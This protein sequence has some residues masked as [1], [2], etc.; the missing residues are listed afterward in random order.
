LARGDEQ[1]SDNLTV[2]IDE[3]YNGFVHGGEGGEPLFD[4]EGQ[5]TPMLERTVRFLQRYLAE[6]ERT[7]AFVKRMVELELLVRRDVQ[8]TDAEGNQY[9]L[10][11]FRVIDADQL[12]KLADETVVEL[13]RQGYLGWIHAQLVSM[14]RLERMPLTLARAA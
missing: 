1:D 7:R 8:L 3:S 4:S 6:S 5:Q 9:A 14:S 13:H 11:D 10:R 2:C 12:D